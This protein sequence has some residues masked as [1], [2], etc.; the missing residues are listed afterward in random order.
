[1]EGAFHLVLAIAA[2]RDNDRL[3]AAQHI[4]RA[5]EIASQ[6]GEERDDFGTEFGPTNVALVRNACAIR[7]RLAAT[8][9]GYPRD[10]ATKAARSAATH[11]AS[12]SPSLAIAAAIAW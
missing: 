3:Q 10:S 2:A 12:V 4:E 5:S 1:L 9:S 11:A 7:N 8:T 6:I